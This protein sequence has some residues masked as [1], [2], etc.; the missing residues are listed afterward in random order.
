MKRRIRQTD[1][2]D[3]L[4]VRLLVADG[5]DP[6]EYREFIRERDAWF[7][8]RGVDPSDWRKVL[9]LLDA[10]HV[11]HG[12]PRR[13]SLSRARMRVANRTYESRPLA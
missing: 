11:A 4:P 7:R 13:S 10:S 5:L 12:L 8:S 3:V 1:V 2:G 6:T 9:P